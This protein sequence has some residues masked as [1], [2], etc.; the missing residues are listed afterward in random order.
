MSEIE[1]LEQVDEN[2]MRKILE[3]GQGCP[4]EMLYL[5]LGCKPIRFTIMMRRLMFFH[6]L[7]NED[8]NSL[9]HR[10]LQA[11]I[12]NPSKDD[13]ILSVESTL[14]ELDIH[15]SHDDIKNLSK[16]TF[17]KFAKKQ[18]EEK[19]L[20]FLNQIKLKHSKVLNIQHESLKMQEY[21][22]P[23]NVR[24]IKLAKFLFSARC[25]MIDVKANFGNMYKGNMKCKLGCDEIDSQEHLLE[26]PIL[27]EKEL[28]VVGGSQY[29]DLFSSQ[30]EDQLRIASVLEERFSRRKQKTK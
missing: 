21:L 20:A 16:E 17:H 12:K 9:I 8:S 28:S 19:A 14:D 6:Y 5:E 24:S 18:I 13:F 1:Q 3:V 25:R 11:Q 30:V 15:L 4:K 10:V 23:E 27:D 7:L 22:L 29:A 2:L 26:C